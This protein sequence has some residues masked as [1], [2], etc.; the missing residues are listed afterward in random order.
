MNPAFIPAS[1]WGTSAI[2]RHA[3]VKSRQTAAGSLSR[4]SRDES[5]GLWTQLGSVRQDGGGGEEGVAQRRCPINMKR[6]PLSL[7]SNTKLRRHTTRLGRIW[8]PW[9]R[10]LNG[11]SRRGQLLGNVGVQSRQNGVN[12]LSILSFQMWPQKAYVVG[13]GLF[14]L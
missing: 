8:P 5:L 11:S 12:L 7:W 6:A 2:L 14:R 1:S 13:R 4:G 3:E 9:D 10:M